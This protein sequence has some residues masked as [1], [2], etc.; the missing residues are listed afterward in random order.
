L[1]KWLELLEDRLVAR[2]RAAPPVRAALLGGLRY[3]VAL[4]RDWL[5]DEINVQSMSLA[6]TTLLSIVPLIAFTIALLKGLGTHANVSLVV[7]E[8]LRP[9]GGAAAELTASA[10][11]VVDNMRGDV[12]GSISFVF[13]AYTVVTT[14]QKVESSFHFV[15]R[16]AR[17]RSLLRRIVEYLVV[18]IVGPILLAAA[19]GVVASAQNSPL[20][21]W[22]DAV[23]PGHS[24]S[25]LAKGLPYVVVTL[26]FTAMYFLIPNTRVRLQAAIIGGVSAGVMWALVGRLFTAFILYSSHTTAVYTGFAVVLTTLIW[27]YLSWLIL[28]LGAQLAFY[29]QF[30][31]YLRPGR[32]SFEI[33]GR[34]RERTALSIMILMAGGRGPQ[35]ESWT[36]ERLAE[37]LDVPTAALAPIIDQLQRA[38]LLRG[39]GGQRLAAGREPADITLLEIWRAARDDGYRPRAAEGSAPAAAA[40]VSMEVDA[41][42]GERL[43]GRTLRDVIDAG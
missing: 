36:A 20:A 39:N 27:I 17:P 9:V 21:R 5:A 23:A 16:I 1:V 6:Y 12:L 32:N 11:Q 31:Q 33:S 15:W 34:Y 4:V 2:A 18:I 28:L 29:V 10:M 42:V 38:G 14:I 40:A 30:P 24:L 35:P 7:Y 13:L 25:V 41:A 19:L 26:V 22:L 43:A 37:A 3:P 8:F